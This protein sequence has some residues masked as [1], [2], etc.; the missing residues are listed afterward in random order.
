M[1]AA[2]N[3][4]SALQLIVGMYPDPTEQSKAVGIFVSVAGIGNVFIYRTVLGL[5]ISAIFVT[6][7]TWPWV[8][9]FIAIAAII[10][11]FL[12]LLLIPK[13]PLPE[14]HRG[15]RVKWLD[16]PGVS[17]LTVAVILFVFAVTSGSID[18]WGS[19]TVIANLVISI[20]LTIAFFI[21][22]AYIPEEVAALPPKVWR[23]ENFGTVSI[24][25]KCAT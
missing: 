12:G 9:Y 4:P 13:V 15:N 10:T 11:G 22:E 16:L 2:L 14:E 23:Y 25:K 8:F 21:W 1:G 24:Q 19:A 18:G 20:V 6:F 7:A 3:V 17:V 5:F